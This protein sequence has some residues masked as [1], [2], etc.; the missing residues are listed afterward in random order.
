MAKV[1]VILAKIEKAKA[2]LAV[3]KAQVQGKLF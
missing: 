2:T 3:S 1:E